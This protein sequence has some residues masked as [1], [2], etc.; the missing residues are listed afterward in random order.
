MRILTLLAASLMTVMAGSTIAPALPAMA[1]HF[2]AE[3]P[4]GFWV[5]L[6]LTMP[7]LFAAIGAPL[8]GWIADRWGRTPLLRAS[9]LLYG[10]AGFSGFLVESLPLLLI[11]RALLG[12]GVGGILTAVTTLIGDYYQGHER[13]RIMG[14]QSSSAGYGGVIFLLLGGAL[15]EW[16]WD[17]PF[18]VY[19]LAFAVLPLSVAYLADRADLRSADEDSTGGGFPVRALMLYIMGFLVMWLFYIVPIQL[20]FQMK[21]L[22]VENTALVGAA[23]ACFNLAA[24]TTSLFYRRLSG[25]FGYLGIFIWVHALWALGYVVIAH[26]ASLPVLLFGIVL[27]GV[28]LGVVMP[29]LNTWASELVP[30]AWRGRVMGGLAT[31]YFLGQFSSPFLIA[32]LERR[33]GIAGSFQ[34]LSWVLLGLTAVFVVLRLR[35][36][37]GAGASVPTPRH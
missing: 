2:A 10:V 17:G 16:R 12:L 13:R 15:A 20:P 24:A 8:A 7:G 37:P 35:L 4:E 25:R 14:L 36:G 3:D 23:L 27:S 1:E 32:P 33:F 11:G 30:A 29:N 18:L 6:V 19:L 9:L 22:G 34:A 21:E 5:R 26:A 28:G 31:S